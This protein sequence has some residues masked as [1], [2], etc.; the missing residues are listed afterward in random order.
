MFWTRLAVGSWCRNFRLRH[1]KK[2]KSSSNNYPFL[3]S[4][5]NL[6]HN[7]SLLSK[8]ELPAATQR[9]SKCNLKLHNTFPIFEV[10]FSKSQKKTVKTFCTSDVFCL[11]KQLDLGLSNYINVPNSDRILFSLFNSIISVV[12]KMGPILRSHQYHTDPEQNKTR[13]R[14]PFVCFQLQKKKEVTNFLVSTVFSSLS[15]LRL[16]FNLC[17][18]S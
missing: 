15:N 2:K 11:P 6:Y 8:S 9:H 12:G 1:L 5:L 4:Y 17:D 14:N 7:E 10:F 13:R 16:F 18:R 3:L